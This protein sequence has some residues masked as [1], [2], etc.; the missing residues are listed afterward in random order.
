M[1]PSI[2]LQTYPLSP[3]FHHLRPTRRSIKRTYTLTLIAAIL[4]ILCLAVHTQLPSQPPKLTLQTTNLITPRAHSSIRIAKATIAYAPS[5]GIYARSLALHVSQGYKTH[6]L[7]TPLV[8]GF[9]NTFLWLQH[10]IT[11]ELLKDENE[12][13]E[14]ILYFSPPTSPPLRKRVLMLRM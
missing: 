11:S 9:A 2:N 5:N 10:V 3:R 6:V 13:A 8:K 14:W 7:R 1:A 4:L 12:R